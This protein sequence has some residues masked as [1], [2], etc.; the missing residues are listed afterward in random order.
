ME[1]IADNQRAFNC[2][3]LAVCEL[4]GIS[5]PLYKAPKS[6]RAKNSPTTK[7][8]IKMKTNEAPSPP[9]QTITLGELLAQEYPSRKLLVRPRLRHLGIDQKAEERP[10]SG[11]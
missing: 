7:D 1:D 2:Y 5:W 9:T 10:V 4:E 11:A 6:L 3:D 8:R